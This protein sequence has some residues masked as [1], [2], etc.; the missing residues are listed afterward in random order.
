MPNNMAKNL[1]LVQESADLVLQLRTGQVLGKTIFQVCVRV[2]I[3]DTNYARRASFSYA[4]VA[5]ANMLF[6]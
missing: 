2:F 4:M 5:N 1:S 6:L 3:S